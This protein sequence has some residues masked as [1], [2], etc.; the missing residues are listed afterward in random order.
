MQISFTIQLPLLLLEDSLFHACQA[1][2]VEPFLIE[3]VMN[4]LGVP[5]LNLF[6]KS[7]SFVRYKDLHCLNTV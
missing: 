1:E 2:L 6:P 7:E 4:Q 5:V 3:Y